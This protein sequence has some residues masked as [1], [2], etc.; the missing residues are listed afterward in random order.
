MGVMLYAAKRVCEAGVIRP[1]QVSAGGSRL[2]AEVHQCPLLQRL[3]AWR[4]AHWAALCVAERWILQH[5]ATSSL[6]TSLS[7]WPR[8]LLRKTLARE[9]VSTNSLRSK[10][11]TIV[12]P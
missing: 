8:M 3:R 10:M 6:T 11:D 4:R 12:S 7:R 9:V 1:G 2:T 5:T